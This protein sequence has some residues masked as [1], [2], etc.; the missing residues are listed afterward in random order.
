MK[1]E[2]RTRRSEIA[3]IVAR[4]SAE[5]LVGRADG[6]RVGAM[7]VLL[8]PAAELVAHRI[9]EYDRRL[10]DDG[11]HHGAGTVM[12]MATAGMSVRGGEQVPADGPLLVVA[13]H[14]G[15]SDAVSIL[16]A[17]GRD[18][19]WIVAADYPFLHALR[20]A[21]ARFVFVSDER[22]SRLAALRRIGARLRRGD[23]VLLF[24]AGALEPE[25]A[26]APVLA[27]D[28]LEGWSR[29]IELFGRLAPGTLIV[30][31]FVRG[32]VS[33]DAFDHALARRRS[34]HAERQR[35]AALLQMALPAYQRVRVDVAFGPP[36]DS[37]CADARGVV[38]AAM[39][40]LMA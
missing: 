10:G 13:N 17:L 25:A 20:R 3:A 4:E 21:N 24:P 22:T 37:S 27:R 26:I 11:F 34:P 12:T 6:F 7:R 35:L 31:A 2:I 33:R 23:A 18:D 38:I 8:R 19:A 32:V 29:S 15:L 28:S 36:I 16:A 40:A 1:I 9:V 30:P 14:P 5:T 39:R